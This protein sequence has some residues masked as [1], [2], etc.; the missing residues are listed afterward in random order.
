MSSRSRKVSK[1]TIRSI[2][3][4]GNRAYSSYRLKEVIRTTPTNL[5]S[6][7]Q[8]TNI[9]DQDRIEADRE[10]LRR[11]YL[12]HGFVDVRISGASAVFD[13]ARSGFIVTF[14]DRGRRTIPRRTVEI[15][16]NVR[17][18]DP[19]LMRARLRVGSGDVYN[20]EA[21]EKSIEEMT[22]EAARQGYAFAAV[23]PRADRDYQT[24]RINLVFNIEDGQRVYI[25]QINVRGNTRTRDYV[26]RREFDV[27]EGDPYNRALIS[28]AERRL[29]NLGYFKEVKIIT[30]PGS[31]PDRVIIVVIGR[32]A[33]D[34][35]ILDRRRIFDRRWISGRGQ[36]RRAQPAGPWSLRQGRGAVRSIYQR[37]QCYPLSSPI[38]LVI[39]WHSGST[40]FHETKGD[41]L[42]F[43]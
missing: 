34:R 16:S 19:A 9:Y 40:C 20:A 1:T 25:E 10:M 43:L 29:K 18:I 14:A 37:L 30:E 21:L 36:H 15:R 5:L 4:V 42:C 32:G 2:E 38:S 24:R 11:F 3:F 17:A 23:R 41:G 6:F 33:V 22:I 31:S 12:K 13:P 27:A 28:R 7:L 39:A 26:I 8:S 35:R